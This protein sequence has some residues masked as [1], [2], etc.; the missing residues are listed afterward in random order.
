MTDADIADLFAGLGEVAIRKMFGG[1]GIYHN[2]L[3]VAVEVRGEVLL[4]ADAVSAPE[5]EAAGA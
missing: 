4:K 1:K 2:G 3:I 5:F